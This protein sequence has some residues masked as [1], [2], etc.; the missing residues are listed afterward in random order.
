MTIQ[1]LNLSK[2]NYCVYLPKTPKLDPCNCPRITRT[3]SKHKRKTL[4]TQKHDQN[5]FQAFQKAPK[6]YLH[7]LKDSSHIAKHIFL[8]GYNTWLR[9][10]FPNNL[11]HSIV[12]HPLNSQHTPLTCQGTLILDA[13]RGEIQPFT[14]FQAMEKMDPERITKMCDT[15]RVD[16]FHLTASSRGVAWHTPR[17]LSTCSM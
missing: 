10:A 1:R 6:Y 3:L 14:N 5:S 8:T 16:T 7:K 13:V 12:L 9:E 15:C 11:Q 17:S 2:Q 4:R